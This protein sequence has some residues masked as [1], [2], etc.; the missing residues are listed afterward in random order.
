VIEMGI[1]LRIE[2]IVFAVLF[3]LMILWI[4]KKE[5][6]L[7]KY[8]L[9]WLISGFL[10]IVAVTIPNFIEKLSSFLGF[11]T[12]SNMMFLIGFLLLLY[13]C[14]TLTVI[15]SKQSSKIRL[16]VQEISLMKSERNK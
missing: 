14:L 15:V 3:M 10:M 13:I 7:I 11:E 4:V 5:K 9:V 2:L 8:A 1:L 12:T 16:L 6:L